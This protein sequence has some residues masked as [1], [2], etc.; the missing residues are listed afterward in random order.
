MLTVLGR[1]FLNLDQ[2]LDIPSLDKITDDILLGIAKTRSSA[3]P[4]NSGPGYV[5]KR[6]NSVP[7]IQRAILGDPSHPY[8]NLITDL[9]GWEAQTFIQYK[10]PSHVLGNCILLRMASSYDA[11]D[12]ERKTIDLPAIRYFES[13]MTWIKDQNIFKEIGR[14]VVLLNDPF[15]K[16]IEH[17]DYADGVSRKDQ[18]I[19]LNPL[20][21]KKFFIKEA[22]N[23]HYVTSKVAFFDSA[24]I[25]GTDPS[26]IST[27]SIRV[28]GKFT[29]DFLK[30]T[31]LESYLYE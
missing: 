2:F 6:Y 9:K 29:E 8:Y 17:S 14:T 15:S 19:W 23:K 18:F 11:K 25:H 21:R 10:W 4:S 1:P 30:K 28:D 26:D 3:G 7:E 5:D 13:L 31:S 12:L 27:F 24:N 22:D 16:A 20:Q